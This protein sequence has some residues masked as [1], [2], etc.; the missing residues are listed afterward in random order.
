MST[1]PAGTSDLREMRNQRSE[2]NAVELAQLLYWLL[3]VGYSLRQME[4]RCVAP[5]VVPQLRPVDRFSADL[6][7]PHAS[8]RHSG[9]NS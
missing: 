1:T 9:G 8:V 4:G 7:S 5:G 6:E 2:S 3:V